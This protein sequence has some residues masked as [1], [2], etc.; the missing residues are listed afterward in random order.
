MVKWTHKHVY[1][2]EFVMQNHPTW[3]GESTCSMQY[4]LCTNIDGP[5]HKE[6]RKTLEQMLRLVYGHYPKGVKFVRE[7]K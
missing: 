4:S 5:D 3:S 2:Y 6:N 7:K 1:V